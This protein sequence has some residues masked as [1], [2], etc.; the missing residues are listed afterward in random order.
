MSKRIHYRACNLCEAICG[1]EIQVDGDE[2]VSI[3]GDGADPLSR[4][5]ICPKAVALKDL[6]EDPDR[7]RRPLRR[8]GSTWETIDWDTAFDL[9][10]DGLAAVY[11]KHGPD[12]IA[13]YLGNPTVHN[14]GALTHSSR[15]FG[16]IR[17]HNRYSATSVDQLPHQLVAYWMYG[18]QLLLPVP[19]IDRTE[20]F[21]VLGANPMASNGSLM[22]VPDFPHR[23]AALRA[24]G[25]KMVVLDPRRSE[26][27]ALA[28]EH[29]F[30]RPGSD[31]AFLIGV[32]KTIFDERLEAPGK[33]AALSDGIASVS[34]AVRAF[35]LELLAAR[36]GIDAHTIQRIAREFARAQRAAAYGRIGVSVQRHGTLS[37]WL[38]QLINLVT[39]NL[40]R[41]GGVLFT[42]PA[43]DTI[44]SP[45]SRPGHYAKW[46]SRVRGLPEFGGELPVAALAEE[47]LTPG[48]GQV[49]AF[50]TI[51]GNPVLS[52]PNG[53]QLDRALRELEFM[54]SVDFYMNETTCHAHVILPPTTTL[55]HDHYDL[56]FHVLAVRN[57]ARF[58]EPLFDKPPDARHDWEIFEAVGQRLAARLGP[59]RAPLPPPQEIVD[60]GL[61]SGPYG[62]LGGH[63]QALSL[64]ALRRAP[65]G[66]DLGALQPSL[67]GRLQHKDK[68]IHCLT[69]ELTRALGGF[70]AELRAPD[71][72]GSERTS[73]RLIGRRDV[74][75]NN[76]WM[77]NYPRLVKGPARNRLLMHPD[78][79]A[80]RG[81]R[82]GAKV[83][84]R[85]RAGE[86]LVDV[87]ASDDVM[88]G[89]VSLPHG[90]GHDRNGVRLRVAHLHAGVSINDVTDETYLDSTS[91]NAALNG[92]PVTV[93]AVR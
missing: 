43:V 31:A 92:V 79:L 59:A 5:H 28:D 32:L 51:A 22:T 46:K 82:D 39:G 44:E 20:Y 53:G 85:S 37:Q 57:T 76:S 3:R 50:V 40:D 81:I 67:P 16:P 72:I 84:L 15:F 45:V 42:R 78:D 24:R 34:Q 14:Y 91:G 70:A 61:R 75:S 73:L 38:I 80:A 47:I 21:L 64:E 48:D 23:L 49:R 19:D 12:A 2:I 10:A 74:R 71:E 13:A 55:E 27:A 86:V 68:K 58:N 66:I 26:T 65:H 1:L 87:E 77:H 62:A 6:H 88:P 90:W 7:L 60:L 54:V 8:S 17:T 11:T 18:H 25:G 52:T 4:G 83:A 36:C 9:V 29:F 33:L 30:V 41:E 89:V 69:P 56:A 63:P 93:E 35:D